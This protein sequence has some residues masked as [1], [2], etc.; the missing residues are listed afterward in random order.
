MSEQK[1]LE[2]VDG[3]FAYQV[4]EKARHFIDSKGKFNNKEM[5]DFLE[6]RIKLGEEETRWQVMHSKKNPE[7]RFVAIDTWVPTQQSSSTPNMA[8]GANSAQPQPY[9]QPATQPATGGY[10]DLTENL[11][12]PPPMEAPP[13]FTD[14]PF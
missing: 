3:M 2:F 6:A 9:Q 7:K 4:H 11:V 8:Q 10:P 13:D 14:V 5:I 1:K 12:P